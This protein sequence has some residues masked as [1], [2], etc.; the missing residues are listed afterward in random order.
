MVCWPFIN[1][2]RGVECLQG[3]THFRAHFTYQLDRFPPVMIPRLV[4]CEYN[5][6]QGLIRKVHHRSNF[7]M[8]LDKTNLV[9]PH[10]HIDFPVHFNID[11]IGVHSMFNQLLFRIII[12]VDA[13]IISPVNS[14]IVWPIRTRF[15]AP[16]PPIPTNGVIRGRFSYNA[17]VFR[18]E[19]LFEKGLICIVKGCFC[20]D[21][22][23]LSGA[24]WKK[25][26]EKSTCDEE[27]ECSG[28]HGITPPHHATAETLCG[29]ECSVHWCR[30]SR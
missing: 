9:F 19:E 20:V 28:L 24:H 4:L 11:L 7:E 2:I 18:D 15:F 6:E 13:E 30:S 12:G 17:A 21:G 16:T 23:A 27:S 5:V 22:E 8:E 1:D 10:D 3:K 26:S 29:A 25:K 14:V